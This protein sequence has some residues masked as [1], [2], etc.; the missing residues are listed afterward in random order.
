MYHSART[1]RERDR[2]RQT[3]LE[4]MGWVI[5]R[6]WPTDWIKDRNTEGERLLA[7]VQAAID[8]YREFVPTPTHEMSRMTDFVSV[9][10]QTATE[11][12]QEGMAEKYHNLRSRYYGQNAREIPTKDMGSIMLKVIEMNIGINKVELFKETAQ[13]GY[14]WE[15]QG[16]VIKGQFEQAFRG[17]IR[18]NKIEVDSDDKVQLLD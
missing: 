13:Y 9:S 10:T 3:V 5:Y 4:D 18:R 8:N 2:L 6:V 7:A 17:L 14:G 12:M 15:R 11:R 1:A 16:S